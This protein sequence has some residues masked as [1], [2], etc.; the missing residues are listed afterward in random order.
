MFLHVGKRCFVKI[1]KTLGILKTDK[2]CSVCLNPFGAP[3][4]FLAN[5]S[6]L[7]KTEFF[8]VPWGNAGLYAISLLD[9]DFFESEKCVL[10]PVVVVRV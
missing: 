6:I 3:T 5:L 10:L 7:Y 2:P 1:H 9:F 4:N 8:G